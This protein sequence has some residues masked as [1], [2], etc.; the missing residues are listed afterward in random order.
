VLSPDA[1]A[2]FG[3]KLIHRSVTH[4]LGGSIAYHW[5]EGGLIVTLKLDRARLST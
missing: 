4:Q 1:S 2:G 5:A 3:S